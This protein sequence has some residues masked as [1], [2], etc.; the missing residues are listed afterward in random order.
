MGENVKN[1][2]EM[3]DAKNPKD[4]MPTSKGEKNQRLEFKNLKGQ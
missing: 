2:R 3:N 4:D 1:V